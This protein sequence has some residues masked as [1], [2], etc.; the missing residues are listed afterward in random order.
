RH[1]QL[2]DAGHRGEPRG[3]LDDPLADR[4]LAPGQPEL[5]YAEPG[6]HARQPLE[7]LERQHR[8]AGLEHQLF[9]ELLPH[10]VRAAVVTAV[11]D[12]DTQVSDLAE[13]IVQERIGRERAGQG[14]RPTENW[15]V[16]NRHWK[17][18]PV[19]AVDPVTEP[20][21]SARSRNKDAK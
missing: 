9:T 18:S 15:Q 14:A 16:D 10:A 5:A 17:N 3:E 1:H 2:L 13:E 8:R 7:L 12:R 11:C 6:E 21:S 19:T 20:T 4:G